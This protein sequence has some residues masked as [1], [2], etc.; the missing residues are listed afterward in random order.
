MDVLL[1]RKG[2]E[3]LLQEAC[4]G[5]CVF[6]GDRFSLFLELVQSE[7]RLRA[8]QAGPGSAGQSSFLLPIEKP[9]SDWSF[10]LISFS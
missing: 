5:D 8:R 9:R 1:W 3:S 4:S 7:S 10:F 6:H 2:N